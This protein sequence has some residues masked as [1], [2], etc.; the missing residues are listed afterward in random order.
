MTQPWTDR[1]STDDAIATAA[2]E[3]LCERDEGFAAGRAA[4]FAAWRAADARHEAAVVRTERAF[5]LMAELPEVR[6]R[7]EMRLA[8]RPRPAT[9]AA[10]AVAFRALG[11][12]AGVAAAAVFAAGLW[13]LAPSRSAGLERFAT[14][15][16]RQEQFALKDGSVVNLNAGSEVR[17]RFTASERRVVLATGEAHFSVTP[18]PAR[19]FIV[20]AAG[21]AVRAV[22][23][24][25][26]VHVGEA[27]VEV[28]V[29]EGKVQVTR[30]GRGTAK[31]AAV[32]VER[33]QLVAGER[34][35]IP[36][37]EPVAPA[38]VEQVTD[39]TLRAATGW[40]SPVITFY[41]LPLRMVVAQFNRRNV[42]Q[43]V[44]ADESIGERRIGG[45]FS[46]DQVEA[47]V[48][49]LEQDGDVV[50]HRGTGGEM[51]LGRRP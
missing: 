13:W 33:P 38:K 45:T 8:Q 36:R 44:L 7:L 11:W 31:A 2:A 1:P 21:V 32:P 9:G 47:F 41:D 28:L 5:G 50:V 6:D 4:A 42:L 25:F 37:G 43:I 23:T 51:I 34:V 40:H 27:G 49:L 18:D 19:P 29:T 10:R 30:E 24:A 39:E 3:W 20:T 17:V 15:P 22:G 48:R 12:A 26:N 14:P 16:Q 35:A 46:V